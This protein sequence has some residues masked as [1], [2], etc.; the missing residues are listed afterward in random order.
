[1]ITAWIKIIGTAHGLFALWS[2]LIIIQLRNSELLGRLSTVQT[3]IKLT[4]TFLGI[5]FLFLCTWF[6]WQL[7]VN[8]AAFAWLALGTFLVSAFSDTVALRGPAGLFN[9]IPTFYKAVLVRTAAALALSFLLYNL[10]QQSLAPNNSFKP[11]P[12]RGAA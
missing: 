6:S 1:M 12:L 8:A 10:P 3:L 4:A 5:A 2:L 7:S 11:T 9:L